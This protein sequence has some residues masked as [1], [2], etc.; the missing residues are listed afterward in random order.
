MSNRFYKI[1]KRGKAFTLV[2]VLAALT[3]GAMILVTVLTVYGRTQQSVTRVTKKLDALRL[4]SEI[5]QRIA[6]DLDQIV[7]GAADTK[8]TIDNRTDRAGFSNARLEIRKNLYNRNNRA[9]EFKKIVWQTSYDFDA[10]S[11]VLY[12]SASGLAL[13]D[14]LLDEN[15]EDSERELFVP[16]CSGLTFFKIQ[17]P[18]KD[19]FLDRWAAT[20]LPPGII[21]TI[22]FAEPLETTTN[23]FEV[24]EEK[25]I[26][27]TIAIDRTRKIDFVFALK[28][29]EQQTNE[30]PLLPQ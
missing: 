27:R 25:K 26:S 17:V 9:Q 29:N 24:P 30:K 28:E 6:E 19:D 22:S 1:E 10:D 23:S 7:A 14:K 11:I 5:L 4:P 12:R 21:V 18:T 16:I 15:K 8:V 20:S 13:E 3:I 2:E